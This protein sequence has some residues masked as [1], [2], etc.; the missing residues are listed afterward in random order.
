MMAFEIGL[1]RQKLWRCV[2]MSCQEHSILDNRSA[3]I[4]VYCSGDNSK[5]NNK[6]VIKGL[7][8]WRKNF[9][10]Y[11]YFTEEDWG[12]ILKLFLVPMLVR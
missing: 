10:A 7:K 5:I 2:G 3:S 4:R 11:F 6:M 9:F 8:I 1:S 12:N